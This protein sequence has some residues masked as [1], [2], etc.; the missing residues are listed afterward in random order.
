MHHREEE[1]ERAAVQPVGDGEVGDRDG[2]DDGRLQQVGCRQ[3]GEVKQHRVGAVPT[4]A[5][6]VPAA[7]QFDEHRHVA[8]AADDHD[9]RVQE[10]EE[11]VDATQ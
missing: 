10:D 4:P 11:R 6:A 2:Q 9:A 1:A 8:G 5:C 7:V 3:V